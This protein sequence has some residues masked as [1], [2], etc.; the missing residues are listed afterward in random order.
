MPIEDQLAI[1]LYH[2]GH[3]GN[4]AGL[5]KV[6]KWSRYSKGTILLVTWRVMTTILCQEFMENA[7]HFLT[8]EEKRAAK[9]WIEKHSCPGW[10]NEWCMVDGTLVPLYGRPNWYGP[11]Y[12]DQK[13]NYS[14]NI[15]VYCE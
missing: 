9:H 1:I 8:A 5:D 15:Q 7:V 3:F 11:S 2:F 14:L 13:C 10:R 4:V 6:A 12:F